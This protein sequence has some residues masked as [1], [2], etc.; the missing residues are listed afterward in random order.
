MKTL[1]EG[2][3]LNGTKK[4]LAVK[5]GCIYL[6]GISLNNSQN[7]ISMQEIKNFDKDLL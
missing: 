5:D 6:E 1:C 2:R 4:I 7:N 3:E